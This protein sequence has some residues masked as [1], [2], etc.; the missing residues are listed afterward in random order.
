[1]LTLSG[2]LHDIAE[3]DFTDKETGVIAKKYKAEILSKVRGKTEV[4]AIGIEPA[5]VEGWRK[6]I[7]LDISVE[8]RMFGMPGNRP[9]AAPMFG[10]SLCDKNALP[11]ILS[12]PVLKAA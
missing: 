11:V 7:G 8:V 2:K 10:L 5:A 4:E 9:G 6:A 1:M 12:K 3:S